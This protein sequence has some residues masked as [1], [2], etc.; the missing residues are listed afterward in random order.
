MTNVP[1][2][3]NG[4][5]RH[6]DAE[7]RASSAFIRFLR[8]RRKAVVIVSLALLAVLTQ[9]CAPQLS[10]QE[11]CNFVMSG[12]AQRVSW[13]PLTPVV[14]YVDS[15]VPSEF[16]GA[17]QSAVD[18]W[19]RSLGRQVLKI[20]GWSDSYPVEKQD[21][22]NVI[23]FNRKWPDSQSRKQAVTTIWWAGDRVFESDISING[24][25]SHYEY[26]WGP[27]PIPRRVD[28]ESLILHELGHVLGLEHPQVEAAGTV[29]ARELK[30]GD[31]RR[32]PSPG[33]VADLKCEY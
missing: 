28:F 23:Y 16:F 2:Q 7:K 1:D 20:G 13:G 30:L 4:R 21:G 31:L 14:M 18:N 32:T 8:N 33:D 6:Q 10:P 9:A 17:I 11:S 12:E 22:V 19:N 27:N 15:S 3:S 24:N 5:D 29:M 26:F 25:A